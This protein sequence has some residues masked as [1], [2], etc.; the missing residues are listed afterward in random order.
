MKKISWMTVILFSFVFVMPL[1]AD[2]VD[3]S[4]PVKTSEQLKASTREMIQA[5]VD[6]DDV[7][8]MT[9]S[10]IQNRFSEK[11][12]IKAQKIIKN[13]H[14]KNLPVEPVMDKVHEGISKNI[15][16][17]TILKALE[18]TRSRYAY[19]YE[20]V[21]KLSSDESQIEKSGTLLAQGMAAGLEKE[22]AE[23]IMARLHDRTRMLD[24][25][26]GDDLCEKTLLL[27]RDMM[28][29]GASSE[30]CAQ[31]VGNAL[32]NQYTAQEIGKIRNTFMH[33]ARFQDP[34]DLAH[35]YAHRIQIGRDAENI[36][37][38]GSPSASEASVPAN[39]AE[40]SDSAGTGMTGSGSE[41]GGS[42]DSGGSGGSDKGP[43][44][45]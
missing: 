7:F 18:K 44:K 39:K 22:D 27:T 16:Q 8:T 29:L 1:C 24:Q 33:Q 14:Q 10:M 20:Y 5:G 19:A 30:G 25:Q 2:E 13:A 43:G 41:T 17:E 26:A 3:D 6:K 42:G 9:R 34:D 36:G 4:L 45:R 15:D 32:Q 21:R 12:I 28:R 23:R 37:G 38:P 31:M 35:Q 11:N 40:A